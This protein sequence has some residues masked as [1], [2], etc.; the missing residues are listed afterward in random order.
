MTFVSIRNFQSFDNVAPTT[1]M[2]TAPMN[3]NSYTNISPQSF[4]SGDFLDPTQSPSANLYGQA[5]FGQKSYTGN[6]FDDEPPLLEG[7]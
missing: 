7:E 5:D 4:G 2:T 1:T 3:P 6:D